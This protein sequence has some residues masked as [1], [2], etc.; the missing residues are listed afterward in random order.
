MRKD[1]N[2]A[3][4]LIVARSIAGFLNTDG[5]DLAGLG[6]REDRMLTGLRKWWGSRRS[7]RS[8]RNWTE[9]RNG[10]RRMLIDSVVR[11]IPAGDFRVGQPVHPDQF[12]GH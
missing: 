9:T 7:T 2:N 6:I 12:P 5:G 3:S 10:Y 8:C 11:K 4:K 1:R